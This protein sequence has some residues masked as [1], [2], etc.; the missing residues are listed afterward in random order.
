MKFIIFLFVT[1]KLIFSWFRAPPRSRR[2]LKVF[3]TSGPRFWTVFIASFP[4]TY[5]TDLIRE[6]GIWSR[7]ACRP[8]TPLHESRSELEASARR[9]LW[10]KST[11]HLWLLEST[12]LLFRDKRNQ[13]TSAAGTQQPHVFYNT[14]DLSWQR[15][16]AMKSVMRS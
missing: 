3:C 10:L 16:T 5:V 4:R 8:R 13:R 11:R 15:N 9:C 14:I 1:L 12:W 2:D 6:I 7:A